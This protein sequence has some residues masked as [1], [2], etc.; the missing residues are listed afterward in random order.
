MFII[1]F[2]ILNISP[3]INIHWSKVDIPPL[4]ILGHKIDVDIH[5]PK[6]GVPFSPFNM[7]WIKI[8]AVIDIHWPNGFPS[9]LI[10]EPTKDIGIMVLD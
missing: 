8:D 10:H 6:I 2:N 3:L 4:G 5:G 9:L 1:I 7:N